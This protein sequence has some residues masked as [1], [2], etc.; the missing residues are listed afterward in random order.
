M[1]RT[2]DIMNLN[3]S[4]G[5]IYGDSPNGFQVNLEKIRRRGKD[6]FEYYD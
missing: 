4:N 3:D 6:C 5:A 2:V 1:E